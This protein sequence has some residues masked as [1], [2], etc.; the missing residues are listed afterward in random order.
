MSKHTPGP[1][2]P[3]YASD[4]CHDIGIVADGGVIAE[5]FHEI[6][7]KNE[8]A[9]NECAA[10]ARLIAVTPE[11]L[12]LLVEVSAMHAADRI[13]SVST[14]EPVTSFDFDALVVRI[15]AAI[16]KTTGEPV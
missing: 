5:C 16:A 4:G 14:G 13:A 8:F 2:E 11:L 3:R 1:W 10:N 12:N 7:V 15:D 9:Y 6:R